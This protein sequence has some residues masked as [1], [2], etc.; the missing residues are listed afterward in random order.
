MS[1][2]LLILLVLGCSLSIL[3]AHKL[4]AEVETEQET[5]SVPEPAKEREREVQHAVEEDT[6][7]FVGQPIEKGKKESAIP[8]EQDPS[9]I[10]AVP[11]PMMELPQACK[12][13]ASCFFR[14]QEICL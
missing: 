3:W 13:I 10:K 5:E 8:S 14:V 6:G 2:G 1:R 12:K 4:E 7:E 9:K 11:I